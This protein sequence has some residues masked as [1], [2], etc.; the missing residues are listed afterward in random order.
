[1]HSDSFDFYFY[2]VK[3]A[4]ICWVIY[5]LG[6]KRERLQIEGINVTLSLR[7]KLTLRQILRL[8]NV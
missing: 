2:S 8:I 6:G 1:M 7:K 3:S 5:I 4:L